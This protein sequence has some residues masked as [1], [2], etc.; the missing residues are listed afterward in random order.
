MELNVNDRIETIEEEIDERKIKIVTDYSSIVKTITLVPV[1]AKFGTYYQAEVLVEG[2]D[3]PFK[4]RV[5]DL[6]I[7][8]ILISQ[9]LG[10]Q[11]LAKKELVKEE[12][13]DKGK[14]YTC[15]KFTLTNG[16]VFRYFIGRADES[17]I[18]LLFESFLEK[19][20][21]KK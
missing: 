17:S 16:K 2:W 1:K 6:F 13:S 20:N 14:V 12:N 3:L 7:N 19:E 9:K 4:T 11:A 8:N 18:D 10:K 15:V 5:D 21:K